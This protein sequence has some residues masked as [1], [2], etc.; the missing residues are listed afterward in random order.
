MAKERPR[1]PG[2]RKHPPKAKETLGKKPPRV[3]RKTGPGRPGDLPPDDGQPIPPHQELTPDEQAFV[4]EWVIDRH[5]TNAYR[6]VRP[7]VSYQM[8]RIRGSEMA[9]RP[10]VR[11]EMMAA[12]RAQRLRSQIRADSLL[13]EMAGIASSDI[14]DL[15]DDQTGL[16]RLPRYIPINTRRA[17]S[18]IRVSRERRTVVQSGST[19]TTVT[20]TVL[21]YRFWN[22]IEAQKELMSYLGLR[23]SLPPIELL[24]NMI[25]PA[26][27]VQVRNLLAAHNPAPQNVPQL[28]TAGDHK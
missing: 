9:H 13:E 20:D 25:P 7:E 5:I 3:P 26:L 17:I 4:D 14:L 18:S 21:E 16:L 12:R 22:K 23:T 1:K 28:T 2:P 10:H 24:L 8:G 19:R 11:A 27:A 6:R 15:V